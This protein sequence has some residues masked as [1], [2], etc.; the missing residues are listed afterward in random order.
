MK[1]IAA[2]ILAALA[3]A[4]FAALAQGANSWTLGIVD[5]SFI[6]SPPPA[7]A[8]SIPKCAYDLA[9]QTG[10]TAAAAKPGQESPLQDCLLRKMRENGAKHHAV[11]FT[12]WFYATPYG[13]SAYITALSKPQYGPVELAT[14]T[15]PGRANNN[16]AFLFVNGTNPPVTDPNAIFA[17]AAQPWKHDAAYKAIRSAH[18]N[19]FVYPQLAFVS[20]TRRDGG[21]QR[22][23]L[24]APILDGCHACARLGTVEIAYEFG[25]LGAPKGVSLVAVRPGSP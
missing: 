10:Y 22:F 8:K 11:A 23:V 14:L 2:V 24:A 5:A 3:V 19:A 17:P 7:V 25:N 13:D 21:G 1:R 20:L 6:W 15:Y 18:A 16:D 9:R 12:A 4:P